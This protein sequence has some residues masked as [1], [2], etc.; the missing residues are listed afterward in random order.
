MLTYIRAPSTFQ[1]YETRAPYDA[2]MRAL[3]F[4][5]LSFRLTA[6]VTS[7][8]IISAA[9]VA[10]SC[11]SPVEHK[12]KMV[13]GDEH[14]TLVS[15]AANFVSRDVEAKRTLLRSVAEQFPLEAASAGVLQ[16]LLQRN[17]TLSQE[18]YNVVIFSSSGELIANMKREEDV[19]GFAALGQKF[20]TQTV[21]QQKSTISRPFHS[22]F[23]GE[24][25]VLVTQPVLDAT[26]SV[27]Y[28]LA[29]GID[30]RA[31]RLLN[32]LKAVKPGA[33][34]YYFIIDSSGTIIQHP[35]RSRLLVNVYSEAG[36]VTP[37]TAA[38]LKGFE[39]WKEGRA[40]DGRKSLIAYKKISGTNWLMGAVYPTSEA[41]AALSHARV[42]AWVGTGIVAALAGIT[43]LFATRKFLAPLRRLREKVE[44]IAEGNV[45]IDVLDVARTD[46]V[47]GLSRAFFALSQQRKAAEEKLANLAFTD[48]L[49]GIGNRRHFE[50][51]MRFF[52]ARAERKQQSIALAYL[53]IDNFKSINDRFGHS[54]GDLVLVE[55][56]RR[57]HS[58]VRASDTVARL[59]GDEFVVV[60]DMMPNK[61]DASDFAI[62][63]LEV[64]RDPFEL[65]GHVLKVTTSIGLAFHSLGRTTVE[66]LVRRADEAL[67]LAKG[68]GRD[69][70]ALTDISEN[71][72]V[73]P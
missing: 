73:E 13:V 26:G 51:I 18:F 43:G 42:T 40:K 28:V 72:V 36:G 6:L 17:Q 56:A 62:R 54:M 3:N 49:T 48:P 45:S 61:V 46:E 39:G 50:K 55:F 7:L 58:T 65:D 10:F 11:L 57:L 27:A 24:P 59:A 14:Y 22:P 47:G 60:Y 52:L 16:T 29:G 33:S 23:L 41:F 30:L 1:P 37:V 63:I 15:S 66:E 53:D 64:I 2:K 34:G 35:N 21:Q 25:V 38:A 32:Q 5:T 8:C 12:M 31:P 19:G 71:K 70:F 4:R 67:Y 69:T 68:A 9:L 44:N 20:F